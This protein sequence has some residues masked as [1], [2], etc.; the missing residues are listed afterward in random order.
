MAA[1]VAR[2]GKAQLRVI[3]YERISARRSGTRWRA[4]AYARAKRAISTQ[5]C[6]GALSQERELRVLRQQSAISDIH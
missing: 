4:R 2:R 5:E 3:C 1:L 6:S